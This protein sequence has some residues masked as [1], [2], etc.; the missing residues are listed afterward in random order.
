MRP[1][2]ALLAPCLRPACA[3]LAPNPILRARCRRRTTTSVPPTLRRAQS[4]TV[5][6]LRF[7]WTHTDAVCAGRLP[8]LLAAL[9]PAKVA[10][11]GCDAAA[12]VALLCGGAFF[13]P[14]ADAVVAVCN[15]NTPPAALTDL[16]SAAL[17]VLDA[18]QTD[19]AAVAEREQ[20]AAAAERAVARAAA[21]PG[22]PPIAVAPARLLT[23][24]NLFCD[25]VDAKAA[26]ARADAQRV[27]DTLTAFLQGERERQRQ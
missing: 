9:A 17:L 18:P 11:V 21:R 5:G 23:G 25:S 27:I 13:A 16:T 4:L 1:A 24:F 15:S 8:P 14:R 10:V 22:A 12:G 6:T 20:L 7:I 26:P 3:L 2:C 19:D